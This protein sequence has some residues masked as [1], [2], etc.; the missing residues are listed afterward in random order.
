MFRKKISA[1]IALAAVLALFP[2]CGKGG[3]STESAPGVTSSSFAQPETS[4]APEEA[5]SPEEDAKK[6]LRLGELLPFTAEE[7]LAFEIQRRNISEIRSAVLEGEAAVQLAGELLNFAVEEFDRKRYD[8]VTGGDINYVITLS[9]GS[10]FEV[11]DDGSSVLINGGEK[12]LLAGESCEL[13]VPESAV[14]HTEKQD[15]PY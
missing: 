10:V 1:L 15:F 9:D 7:V 6:E 14:W 13:S 8:P 11:R 4:S 2:A 3:P 5:G 12:Y